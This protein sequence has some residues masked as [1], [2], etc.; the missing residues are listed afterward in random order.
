MRAPTL[1]ALTPWQVAALRRYARDFERSRRQHVS[2]MEAVDALQAVKR[3]LKPDQFAIVDMVAG[4]GLTVSDL[5]LKTGR[6]AADLATLL[7][8]AATRLGHHY[9]AEGAAP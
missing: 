3:V 7:S 8:Q 6:R 2:R 5:A 4:R 9:E 1:P